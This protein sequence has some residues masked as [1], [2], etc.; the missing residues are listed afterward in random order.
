[1]N[2]FNRGVPTEEG[3]LVWELFGRRVW[4]SLT[5]LA[6]ILLFGFVLS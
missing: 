3:D 1:M 2:D 4:S 6:L 5:L